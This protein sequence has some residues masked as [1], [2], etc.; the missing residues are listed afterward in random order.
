VQIA[1][2]RSKRKI[3]DSGFTWLAMVMHIV[4]IVLVTFIY[5]VFATFSGM[6]HN[7]MPT[8]TTSTVAAGI[9]SL[10]I[11][12]ANS[13]QMKMLLI[14]ITA[15]ALVLTVANALAAYATGG[16]HIYKLAFYLAITCVMS[17][18]VMLLV[19]KVVTLLF[20]GM[21]VGGT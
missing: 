14:M 13:S 21:T 1:L 18:V 12:A 2:L 16:G 5:Q 4:L 6:V 7:L 10:T 9:P 20:S 15:V 17:G 11:F 8:D 3:V 19:P